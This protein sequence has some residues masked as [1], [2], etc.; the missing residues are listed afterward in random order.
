MAHTNTIQMVTSLE[1]ATVTPSKS[2]NGKEEFN[3]N[4]SIEKDQT[5]TEPGYI[6][7]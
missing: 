4:G 2:L 7:I 5:D 6:W 1:C 3:S